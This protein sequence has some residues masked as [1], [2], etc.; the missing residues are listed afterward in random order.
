MEWDI[1]I[2]RGYYWTFMDYAFDLSKCKILTS[3]TKVRLAR[4]NF[5]SISE[6]IMS[7]MKC[8]LKYPILPP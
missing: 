2:L 3:L 6:E 1:I 5:F 4:R 7:E 8:R